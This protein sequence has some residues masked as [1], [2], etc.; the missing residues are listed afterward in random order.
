MHEGDHPLLMSLWGA[1]DGV[2]L[3]ESDTPEAL[4]RFLQRNPE[5]NLV[6]TSEGALIGSIMAGQDGWRGYLYH[7]AV[8]PAWRRQGV[9]SQLVEAAIAAIRRH[10]IPKIHCLVK[11]DNL[12]AQ[13]FWQAH[14]FVQRDDVLDYAL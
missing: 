5:T 6:A 8:L 10:D 7:V 11:C 13:H 14:G 3:R 4:R 9:G 2:I 12:A 1:S